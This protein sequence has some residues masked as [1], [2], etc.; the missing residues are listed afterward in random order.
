MASLRD[1]AQKYSEII[2][3]LPDERRNQALRMASDAHALTANRIQ[4]RGEDA[5]GNKMKLYSKKPNPKWYALNP[6]DFGAPGKITKF[7]KKVA[8][9]EIEPTYE[10]LRKEYGLPID[11]RTLTFQGQMFASIGFKVT[12]HNKYFTE[13]TIAAKD[14]KNKTKVAA[15]SR[16]VGINILKF[17]DQEAKMINRLNTERVNKLYKDAK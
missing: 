7:K 10:N 9:K 5:T 6:S 12:E 4:N 15:N 3:K 14:E 11:K 13:V 16:I 1:L 2:R 17:G 8:K